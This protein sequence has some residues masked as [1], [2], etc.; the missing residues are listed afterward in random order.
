MKAMLINAYGE[1]AVFETAEVDKPA[2]KA[3]HVLVKI[4]ASSVNPVDMMIR[5]MGKDSPLSPETPAILGMDF[6]GTVETVGDSVEG[7][8][9]GDEV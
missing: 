2:V 7:Y 3:G 5:Q 1:Q 8:S 6:A 4:A 9:I